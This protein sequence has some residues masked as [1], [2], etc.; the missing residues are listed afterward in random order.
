MNMLGAPKYTVN[1]V[2][3][4]NGAVGRSSDLTET[5]M[6]PEEGLAT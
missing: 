2:E 5:T 1:I 6:I 4:D 3:D